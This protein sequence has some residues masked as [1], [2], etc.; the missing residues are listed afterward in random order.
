MDQWSDQCKLN[1]DNQAENGSAY[2]SE[3]ITDRTLIPENIGIIR[4]E[5][6]LNSKCAFG[7]KKELDFKP[8]VLLCIQ[9]EFRTMP[10][11]KQFRETAVTYLNNETSSG[12]SARKFVEGREIYPDTLFLMAALKKAWSTHMDLYDAGIR[13]LIFSISI[14]KS[15]GNFWK[16]EEITMGAAEYLFECSEFHYDVADWDEAF[17]TV[18]H[19]LNEDCR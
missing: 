2:V 19:L 5:E 8:E 16:I 1:E 7:L 4:S 17:R 11:D 12:L 9:T 14:Q 3:Q 15:I 10:T 13:T 6:P 18:V